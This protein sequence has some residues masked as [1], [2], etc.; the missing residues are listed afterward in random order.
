MASVA[1]AGSIARLL[2]HPMATTLWQAFI[3]LSYSQAL[4]TMTSL[5]QLA[6]GHV[7]ESVVV[8]VGAY[9]FVP[10]LIVLILR[11]AS[12]PA[13]IVWTAVVAVVVTASSLVRIVSWAVTQGVRGA[14]RE[15][16]VLLRYGLPRVPASALEPALDLALPWM[17]VVSGAGLIGAGYLAIGLALMRPLNPISGALSQVLIPASAASVAREEF[18]EHAARIRRVGRWALHGGLFMTFQVAIWADV[19]IQLWLGPA[20]APAGGV[21]AIVCLS[22]APSFLFACLRGLIDG[23][24]ERAVNTV[25]LCIAVLV[26]VGVS[27]VL[28]W[29]QTAGVGSLG[30][31]YLVSRFALAGLTIRYLIRANT[32]TFAELRPG[33]ALGMSVLFGLG[34]MVLRELLPE[35][36]TVVAMLTFVPTAALL[37]TALFAISETEQTQSLHRRLGVTL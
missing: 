15:V 26:F 33:A 37:F 18:D 32:V 1:F 2:D 30:V 21:A 14:R 23:E 3:L 11:E 10:L 17:A 25:N 34:G 16:E 31:A 20:Y 7:L 13:V 8:T 12:L 19:L 36:L 27:I 24:T 5:I 35:R 28:G 6:R 29:L 9:G 22:L 4:A